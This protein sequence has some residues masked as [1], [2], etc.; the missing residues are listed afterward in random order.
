[1]TTSVALILSSA[2][3][4]TLEFVSY[5]DRVVDDLSTLALVIGANSSQSIE[6]NSAEAVAV[7]PE[8]LRIS[9]I[10]SQL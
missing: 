8:A 4:M 7:S 6:L 2:A 3:F 5:R 9:R 1:M 10:L